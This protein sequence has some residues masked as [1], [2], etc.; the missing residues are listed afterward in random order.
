MKKRGGGQLA[1][2]LIPLLDLWCQSLGEE[3]ARTIFCS[4]SGHKPAGR[5]SGSF[6]YPS[7]PRV[8]ARMRLVP[9]DPFP[10]PMP[11]RRCPGEYGQHMLG[12]LGP[13]PRTVAAAGAAAAAAAAAAACCPRMCP[14]GGALPGLLIAMIGA[15]GV[16]AVDAQLPQLRLSSSCSC[17]TNLPLAPAIVAVV[18][19]CRARASR[20]PR[21]LCPTAW[22][23]QTL[24]L[25]QTQPG[26]QARSD[27]PSPG[28]ARPA[29]QDTS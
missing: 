20:C 19:R 8:P 12:G 29:C 10:A 5:A 22:H 16:A 4:P 21:G 23:G 6:P 11:P 14:L 9:P 1:L 25:P 27:P 18:L 7:L 28:G 26:R 15:Q 17:P 24:W 2:I 13:G 3:P